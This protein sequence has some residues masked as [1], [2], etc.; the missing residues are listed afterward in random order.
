MSFG[1]YLVGTYEK[2]FG[3]GTVLHII[4]P[5][6]QELDVVMAFFD[7]KENFQTCRKDKLTPNDLWEIIVPVNVIVTPEFGVVKI[8][9]YQDNKPAEGIVG[10][11]MKILL[12][13]N[14]RGPKT[15]SETVL[16]S[17]PISFAEVELPRILEHCS[18]I[19]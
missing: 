2:R 12:E 8:L 9:S 14:L 16:A 5:T 19:S 17:V 13:P 7:D 10:Y 4:N 11:Q 15:F 3:I 6:T 18:N 1:A